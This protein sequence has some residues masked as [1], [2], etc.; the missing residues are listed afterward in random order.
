MRKPALC[1]IFLAFPC[2]AAYQYYWNDIF[3]ALG[4]NWHQNGSI[5]AW[6]N[7]V[8]T[9][10]PTNGGSLISNLNVPDGTPRYEVRSILHLPASGGTY[11]H[12]LR[13]SNDALSAPAPAGTYYAIELQNPAYAQDGS[14][15]ATLAAYKRVSGVVTLLGSNQTTCSDGMILRS[16]YTG[17]GFLAYVND[18]LALS[19]TDSS[20]AS[21]KP[22]IGIRDAPQVNSIGT[23]SLGGLDTTAPAAL[24]PKA[25]TI[26]AF[27]DH[28]ELQ[29]R[30]SAD[31]PN[32][33]GL[34]SYSLYRDG[35]FLF[36]DYHEN[37]VEDASVSAGVT[38]SYRVD[39]VDFHG[40]TAST[41]VSVTTPSTWSMDPRQVGTRPTGVYWGGG[42]EQVDVRSGNLNYSI[43][44][45]T[46]MSRN[47]TAAKLG[48][49]YNSQMWRKD[50]NGTW[51]RG[52]DVGYGLGW[53]LMAGSITPVY[54]TSWA[55]HHFVYTDSSGAEYRLNVNDSG[56]WRST[57]AVYVY[58]DPSVRRLYFADGSYWIMG[59]ISG[60]QESDAGT[61][62]PT[63]IRDSN[64]NQVFIQYKAGAGCTLTNTSARIAFVM[65]V[66]YGTVFGGG[67]IFQYTDEGLPHLHHIYNQVGTAENY[68]LGYLD[69]SLY[70]PYDG[71]SAGP[72]V[73]VLTSLLNGL[74]QTT[75]F[76]N[77]AAINPTGGSGEL[78]YVRFP[79]QGCIGW[80]YATL[81]QAAI[82]VRQVSERYL[83]A[84]TC[85]G[86]LTW[87]H[88]TIDDTSALGI[89]ASAIVRDD[90]AQS[91]KVWKFEQ[92]QPD[93]YGM[94]TSFTERSYPAS[95]RAI[96]KTYTWA[97]SSSNHPYISSVVT[98]LDPGQSYGVSSKTTQT[99]DSYG[100][101]I[102]T[103][104]FGYGNNGSV[105]DRTYTT[106]Y[107]SGAAHISR[108]IRNRPLT[109]SLSAGGQNYS[110]ATYTY[111]TNGSANVT[112]IGQH[113]SS[114]YGTSL[115]AR[116]NV[117]TVTTMTG[118][119]TYI[120]DITGTVIQASGTGMPT[121]TRTAAPGMN[122][123]MPGT[124]TPN[125]ESNLATSYTWNSFLGLSSYTGPGSYSGSVSYDSTARPQSS[126]SPAGATT[127]YAYTDTTVKAATNGHWTKTTM[128]G[129]GR[130]V[131]V[132]TGDAATTKSVVDTEYAPCACSP[133]GKMKRVS[134]PH[135][136]GATPVWTTYNYDVMGRTVSV[137][138]PD[139]SVTSYVYQGNTL[140][141]TDAAGKWKK[142][143][144]D[145]FG[146]LA[147]VVEPKDAGNQYTTTYTYNA[148]NKLTGVSMPRNGVTQ[149][150]SFVYDAAQ[151][152]QS[153][154]N[155]ES[156]TTTYSYTP[157]GRLEYKVDAS[158]NRVEY[159]YDTY[160]R[161][162]QKRQYAPGMVEDTC[163]RVDYY[164]DWNPFSA[165]QYWGQLTAVRY[166]GAACRAGQNVELYW[167][168]AGNLPVRKDIQFT[169]HVDLFGRDVTGSM[170]ASFEYNNEGAL[171]AITYPDGKRFYY[172][173]D[174][175]GRPSKLTTDIQAADNSIWP[176]DY[177]KDVVYGAAGELTQWKHMGG[178]EL[179]LM[180]Q[181]LVNYYTETRTY[182]NRL[183]MTRI[184]ASHAY[185][186]SNM[187]VE[188]RYDT[189]GHNN[190]QIGSMK[191][192]V[193][194]EEVV[195]TYDRL[196]RLTRAETVSSLW[197]QSYTMDGF[198]NLTAQTVTKG[199]APA[200]SL[201]VSGTTNRITSSGFSYNA[202]GTMATMPNW[203][204]MYDKE[205]RLVD[206]TQSQN[207]TESYEYD[208]AGRRI[209]ISNET[210][211]FYGVDGKRLAKCQIQEVSYPAYGYTFACTG[212]TY[213]LGQVVTG[214]G[215]S[216]GWGPWGAA[217][218]RLGS[219][220]AAPYGYYYHDQGVNASSYFPYGQARTG[221][222]VWATYQP[223]SVSG[224]MYA[225]NREYSAAYGRFLT[226]DPY[227]A[228]GG[229]ADPGSWNRYA[230]VGNDPVNFN[231]PRGLSRTTLFPMLFDNSDALGGRLMPE[232]AFAICAPGP[233][234]SLNPFC[235]LLGL[236]L[237][238]A[239]TDAGGGGGTTLRPTDA[240]TDATARNTLK[241]RLKGFAGS[242][243]D[244]VFGAVIDGYTT[245]D[246][247]ASVS[248]T[249][250]YNVNN[251]ASSDLTQDQ[252]S[253]N[254]SSTLLSQ[255]L[256]SNDPVAS[257]LIGGTVPA[258]LLGAN[259]FS[260]SAATFQG[261]VLLH[262]LL[263]AYTNWNDTEVF[264]IFGAY[265]LKNIHGDTE[266]ISAWMSTDCLRTPTSM[267][268]W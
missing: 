127:T 204:G 43:P 45:L 76:Q 227:M 233:E 92:T 209:W 161:V 63:E 12:Y 191:D 96:E 18:Q 46:A 97:R 124:I 19:G 57:E 257:T 15:S 167:Y 254:G 255:S 90:S 112:G 184:T 237:S 52:R 11:I 197:G 22:G 130:T 152:L 16:V 179:D 213:F 132:E 268:W 98:A 157:Y 67:Y 243:C 138:A 172:T 238:A 135:A 218:D 106:T 171:T 262:E 101:V 51:N 142:Y 230:Y 217:R 21:G 31:D 24:A 200:M 115:L 125:S 177:V 38:Y 139:G 221:G 226:P 249:E 48:L 35:N 42:G 150:R 194:G 134:M 222:S 82:Q 26:S 34:Y 99:V 66:R 131:K 10:E 117:A 23:T 248:S 147:R 263:H 122:N 259:F 13:A 39:A 235:Y 65:D 211:M 246:I 210:M 219:V 193:S 69:Y 28:V 70:D 208:G 245:K 242:N 119:R 231:D 265:G 73:K 58:Y 198:G 241:A 165:N 64:G 5:Y 189:T 258:V 175:M 212:I 182:N 53:R 33:I 224:T 93:S 4:S 148:F 244:K 113:A 264:Q 56:I 260:N 166:G 173:L 214:E 201:A 234:G 9:W 37:Q 160:N 27:S 247:I 2:L 205:S 25:L 89:P 207:G 30:A 91:E 84:G 88:L 104:L 169:R 137:T 178:G 228:S 261:N 8:V 79:Q 129:I 176:L 1:L 163:R 180:N 266:D 62:Y 149:T 85:S 240:A 109:V 87:H 126:V 251:Q 75:T 162:T 72:A 95:V 155:P 111:D 77:D 156:G 120:Y 3:L 74:G 32:G 154:A 94:V 232:G 83:S 250:F 181:P 78:R 168:G 61:L 188:Y 20:I 183:Q 253:G 140:T 202:N 256:N 146:N 107:L 170:S 145:A 116:G 220:R 54:S 136:A 40:N 252:V 36:T 121:A 158:N 192:W 86:D 206:V 108:Y 196:S 174:T 41:T 141:V 128:D 225:M 144:H 114:E 102:E 203:Q 71:Q 236:V 159:S 100:N 223:S 80:N 190:G 44:L 105:A 151:Q 50:A 59:T 17:S 267:T 14:C 187:D 164:W 7:K 215:E 47:G 60:G 68:T 103:R 199:S 49:S 186:T 239:G 81:S 55:L 153:A 123:T 29:W 143:T 195:Y 216:G 185:S 229:V 6:D 133:M 110:L 118:T